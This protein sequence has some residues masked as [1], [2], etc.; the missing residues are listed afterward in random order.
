MGLS[1][2]AVAT[3][4]K[5]CMQSAHVLGFPTWRAFV[6]GVRSPNHRKGQTRAN[7]GGEKHTAKGARLY[8]GREAVEAAMRA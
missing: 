3:L 2:S 1:S 5:S 7:G 6:A 4:R 8:S